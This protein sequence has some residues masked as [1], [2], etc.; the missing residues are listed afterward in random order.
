MHRIARRTSTT[1]ESGLDEVRA[2]NFISISMLVDGAGFRAPPA[3]SIIGSLEDRAQG[4][5]GRVNCDEKWS[6]GLH[7]LSRPRSGLL[8]AVNRYRISDTPVYF[9]IKLVYIYISLFTFRKILLYPSCTY[10][11]PIYKGWNIEI[12]LQ[13]Y[14]TM[15][16]WIRQTWQTFFLTL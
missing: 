2:S 4:W 6:K 15:Y 12:Y 3:L 14:T 9:D 8:S 10:F 7:F 13:R 16:F 11:F 1:G 5:E